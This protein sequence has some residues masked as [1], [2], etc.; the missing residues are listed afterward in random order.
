MVPIIGLQSQSIDFK[1]AFSQAYIISGEPVFIELPM[2]FKS[3]LGQVNVVIR[4]KK[5]L[6]GQ[7][8]YAH[9]CYKKCE[10]VF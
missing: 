1:N 8:K 4:L 3:Y 10:M 5:S 7:A 9:P 2:D 6:N